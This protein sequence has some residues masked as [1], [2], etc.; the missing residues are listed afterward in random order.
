MNLKAEDAYLRKPEF[1]SARGI[2]MWTEKEVQEQPIQF[3]V[4]DPVPA[5]GRGH[6]HL[7]A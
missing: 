1:L 3:S 5:M 6:P 2:E 4:G 7:Q